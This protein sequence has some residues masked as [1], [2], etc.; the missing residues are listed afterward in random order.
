MRFKN[1]NSN[2][3]FNSRWYLFIVFY[4]YLQGVSF[5]SVQ[6]FNWDQFKPNDPDLTSISWYSNNVNFKIVWNETNKSY[7]IYY[8]DP[9]AY[10]YYN[11]YHAGFFSDQV[12]DTGLTYSSGGL[13]YGFLIHKVNF[14]TELLCVIL[15]LIY[16]LCFL[17]TLRF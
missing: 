3:L 6:T 11:F 13:T 8:K 7:Q 15:G 14:K 16:S 1:G 10:G 2:Y 4:L 5:S 9:I 17:S 12:N